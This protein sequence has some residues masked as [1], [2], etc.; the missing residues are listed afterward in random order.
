MPR[1][2]IFESP[3]YVEA[4][5]ARLRNLFAHIGPAGLAGLAGRR[6][7]ELGCGTGEL[8]DAF[9][10]RGATVVSVDARAAFVDEVR[11]RHPGRH[12]HVADLEAWDPG[13][14]GR[15]DAI[16]CFGLLY[17]LATPADLLA[18]C[19]RASDTLYL[20]TVVLDAS[21]PTCPHTDEAGDDQAFSGRG[22]RPSARWIQDVLARNGFATTDISG[23]AANWGGAAPSVFD[24][25]VRDTGTWM[26]GGCLLRRMFVC[27]RV[28]P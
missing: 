8:G 12:A 19:T 23:A 11:A 28:A 26:R 13:V 24:W 20:E 4:R 22:C 21:A 16:L 25:D 2:P 17:H 18:A 9:A 6:V 7:L 15:F 5:Q 14:L 1:H 3:V 27:T 10:E